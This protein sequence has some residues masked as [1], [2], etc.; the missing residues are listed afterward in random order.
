M[1]IEVLDPS[2]TVSKI[3]DLHSLKDA[4]LMNRLLNDLRDAGLPE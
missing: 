2:Y 1:Q 4:D 3:A